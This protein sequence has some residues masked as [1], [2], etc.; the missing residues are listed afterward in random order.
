MKLG[1]S[2]EFMFAII[3]MIIAIVSTVTLT[4]LNQVTEPV[5]AEQATAAFETYLDEDFGTTIT[6]TSEINYEYDGV[7]TATV[8]TKF[9]M[10]DAGEAFVATSNGRNGAV[11]TWIALATDGTVL[12]VR[13]HSHGET[14]GYWETAL[15][16]YTTQVELTE[17]H[18]SFFADAEATE[19]A[20]GATYTTTAIRNAFRAIYFYKEDNA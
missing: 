5:I 10:G 20:A 4:F 7:G 16:G 13:L 18:Y 1:Q 11:E 9:D 2:K 12:S 14:P 3:L 17:T 8:V 15:S 6:T 19:I